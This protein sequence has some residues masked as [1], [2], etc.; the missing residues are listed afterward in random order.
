MHATGA[1]EP[2]VVDECCPIL[3]Y[4]QSMYHEMAAILS[5]LSPILVMFFSD[6]IHGC[7]LFSLQNFGDSEIF[8]TKEG[9]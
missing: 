9:E 5:G 2:S 4:T 7:Q 6:V 3:D 8:I 1:N